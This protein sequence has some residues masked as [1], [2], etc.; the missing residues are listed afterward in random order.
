MALL[1]ERL[2]DH[3]LVDAV[4][5][6]ELFDINEGREYGEKLFVALVLVAVGNGGGMGNDEKVPNGGI[7]GNG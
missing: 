4:V 1:V 5:V 3:G 7:D 6:P 2:F